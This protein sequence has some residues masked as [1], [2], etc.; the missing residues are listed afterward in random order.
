M[1]SLERRLRQLETHADTSSRREDEAA[2]G[3][4]VMRRLTDEE[5]ERYERALD[6]ALEEGF[7]E[8]DRPILERVE[9]LYEEMSCEFAGA[10]A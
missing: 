4:E 1:A 9:R 8:E 5:L 6:R 7:A 2:I 3:G 10:Q